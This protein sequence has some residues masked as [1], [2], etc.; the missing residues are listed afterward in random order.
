MEK[1]RIHTLVKT[2]IITTFTFVTALIWR[3]VIFDIIKLMIPQSEQLT[4]KIIFAVIATVLAILIMY[5]FLETE[6]D[7]EILLKKIMKKK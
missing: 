4:A 7:T 1:V 3:D 6:Y 5:A 2:S